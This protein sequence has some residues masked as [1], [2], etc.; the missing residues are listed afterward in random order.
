M[1]GRQCIQSF[2]VKKYLLG[3]LL[4]LVVQ[5][6][7]AAQMTAIKGRLRDTAEHKNLSFAV[8]AVLR[9][10]STLLAFTRSTKDGSFVIRDLP[11]GHYLLLITHPN[12]SDYLVPMELI[13]GDVRD[14]GVF[15]PSPR[16]DT[17]AP[18]TVTPKEPLMRLKGDT[19]EYTTAGMK[20]KVNAT[21]EDLLQRLPG[22][23]VDQD[24]SITVNGQKIGRLLV[25]GEDIFGS[26]P[27]IVT[28]NF[29]ADMIN[30]VQVLDKKSDRAAFTG[31]D[32]G[33][34]TKTLNL[35]LKEDRK[36]GYF[37]K[38][39]AGAGTDG[40]YNNNGLLG[41]F[42][43]KR[44]F[45]ALGMLANTGTTGFSGS[46]GGGNDAV[47]ISLQGDLND[48]FAASAGAG[49]P[50]VIGGGAH[51]SNKWNNT[52]EHVS[53]NYSFGHTLTY[54]V[55]SVINQQI[56]PDMVY[57][58]RQ[59]SQSV[60]S[61]DLHLFSGV[62]DINPDTLSAI[63][64]SSNGGSSMANNQFDY[65]AST[66]LNDTLANKSD[67]QVHSNVLSQDFSGNFA[68]RRKFSKEG[69]LFAVTG[70]LRGANNGGTGYFYS[71]SHFFK[72]D[73]GM[74]RVDT[75]DQKKALTATNFVIE[76]GLSYTEPLWKN[77]VLAMSYDLVFNKG[78][79]L[80]DTYNKTGGK[81][82]E[83]VDSLSSHFES[84]VVTQKTVVNLQVNNRRLLCAVGAH[85]GQYNYRMTD[86]IKSSILRNNH[87]IIIPY[88]R[89]HFNF[90]DAHVFYFSY[91][92]FAEQPAMS[93][94]LPLQNNN[95][96]LHI[97]LGNSNLR[98]AVSRYFEFRYDQVRRTILNIGFQGGFFSNSISTRSYTDSLGRQVSQAVNVNGDRK[99]ALYIILNRKIQ[100]LNLD[101][102]FDMNLTYDRTNNFVNLLPNRN[103]I[104]S[105]YGRVILE[106]NVADKYLLQVI[107][108]LY[109]SYSSSSINTGSVTR[110]WW[111]YHRIMLDLFLPLGFE[112]NVNGTIT[113][114][115][116]TNAFDGNNSLFM[117]DTYLNRNF[118][119]NRLS[120]R[121]LVNDLFGQNSGVRRFANASQI[122]EN[123]F[124]VA[125]RFWMI[126][127]YYQFTNKRSEN[128][129]GL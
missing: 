114:L 30:K 63:H 22:V 28:R 115:Q 81:Y 8:I 70:G 110:Y 58:Q 86:A 77:T 33:R 49:I 94:L 16:P 73:G 89:G 61:K 96:P 4:L 112:W 42:K 60:N 100:P 109:Y 97:T 106:R 3:I 13:A 26:D 53:G 83:H 98:P 74:L 72:P 50:Q 56:L 67:R 31:V 120:L 23:Q 37:G 1:N 119:D 14:L 129:P 78:R 48:A 5:Y 64:I 105:A 88:I 55:S 18:V 59:Q 99:I 51:Y 118:L 121:L 113:V 52:G 85:L 69:R 9:D 125:G 7:L 34:T 126:S 101:V 41:S 62:Y 24:G 80:Y 104:Y 76:S 124:N 57:V 87:I 116:K 29:N 32:D 127:L 117:C 68:W 47:G 84:G 20:L 102:G 122:T 44:Q 36:K 40:Y 15:I 43:G 54:P 95:D 2:L 75:L 111:Q 82:E 65:A 90:D 21:V 103:N 66:Y 17:L 107:S 46:G 12:L 27:K 93:Q 25:D 71:A 6:P 123:H 45:A 79:S 92:G 35:T 10:D 11:G 39:E 19:L 128:H 91:N 108:G 38:V